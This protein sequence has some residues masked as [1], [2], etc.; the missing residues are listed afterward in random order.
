MKI[1]HLFWDFVMRVVRRFLCTSMHPVEASIVN[2]SDSPLTWTQRLKICLAVLS[3]LHDPNGMQ[4]RVLH[5]DIKSSNILLD[6]NWNAKVSDFGLSKIGPANE[7]HTADV[8]D[9]VGTLGYLHPLYLEMGVLTKESDVYSLGVVLFEVLCGRLCFEYSNGQYQILVPLWK[10]NYEQNKL[11]EIIFQDLMQQMDT[12]SLETFSD[13][14]YQ[15]LQKSREQRSMMTHIV[16][17][18]E[19]ALQFQEMYKV[20]ELSM[21]YSAIIKTA[22]TPLS[23][24]SE[25][26]LKR[27]FSKGILVN[28]RKTWFSRNKNGEVG[29]Y[30]PGKNSRFVQVNYQTYRGRFIAHARTRF[31][32]PGIMYTV[33]LVFKC[34]PLQISRDSTFI[35]LKYQLGEETESLISYLAYPRENGW[36]AV[37]LYQFTSGSTHIDLNIRFESLMYD[38]DPI[39]P[40]IIIEG[41]EFRPLEKWFSLA[42]NGKKCVTLPAR[43]TLVKSDWDWKHLPES[44]K[45]QHILMLELLAKS[46]PKYRLLNQLMHVS[47]STN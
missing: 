7:Q 29:E 10:Q 32:S 3:Y 34:S 11:E 12:S 2:L 28:G 16:E 15:C 36:L 18:L 8:S 47:L 39:H 1:S 5:R 37:E 20:I 19:I 4:Q 42:K 40:N 46:D 24:R 35:K 23:F 22:V 33:N 6:E 27:L 26:E 17:K 21:E 31:L 30:M 44:R 41:I 13:I 9:V 25:E 43:K 38:A 14:A 45:L